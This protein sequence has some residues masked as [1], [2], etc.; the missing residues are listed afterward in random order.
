MTASWGQVTRVEVVGSVKIKVVNQYG[1]P[2]RGAAVYVAV[3]GSASGKA[4]AKTDASGFVTINMPKRRISNATT[5]TFTVTSL[6]LPSYTYDI[7]S[8]T[9]TNASITISR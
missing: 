7:M 8:N 2:L 3:T 9:P 5:Y 4:A 6:A 1:Q